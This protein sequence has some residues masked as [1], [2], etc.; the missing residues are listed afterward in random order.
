MPTVERKWWTLAVVCVAVFMLLL[1]I[2]IVNVALPDIA[3]DLHANFSAIQWV[4]DAYSLMLAA[5]LLTAGSLG[6]LLGRKK[7]FIA[8]LAI[9]SL[10]SLAC[11]LSG[12]STL[13]NLMR[14]VQG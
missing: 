9:F 13:L 8:G 7:I 11:G 1:D 14:G 3:K 10:A 6:D 4:I 2:T 5:L 12:S